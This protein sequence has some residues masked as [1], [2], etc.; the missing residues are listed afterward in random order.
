MI[1]PGRVRAKL[2][3]LERY[4]RRLARLGETP[5]EA[6]LADHDFEGRYAVQVAAQTCIDLANH[7][8]A[9]EG[10]APAT[11]FA[12]SFTRLHEHAVIDSELAARLQALTRLRNLL[13]HVYA[14]VDD[15]RIHR[16]LPQAVADLDAFA[17]AVAG[18]VDGG[19]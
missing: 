2:A 4:R 15:A 18:M 11:D 6:Y 8:I 5:Q 13:V 12:E 7:V 17:R 3:L 10:W 16:Y 1:D 9:S 19:H 14:E